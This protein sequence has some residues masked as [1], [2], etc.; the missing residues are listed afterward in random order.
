MRGSYANSWN[1]FRSVSA[2]V[3][4]VKNFERDEKFQIKL[5]KFKN[6]SIIYP[7]KLSEFEVQCKLYI[8]LSK[9]CDVRGEV[10]AVDAETGRKRCWFD[11]VVFRS[12]KAVCIVEV[13]DNSVAL[14]IVNP[15]VTKQL[16]KYQ[17]FGVPVFLCSNE[18]KIADVI[19]AVKNLLNTSK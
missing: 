16:L 14:D 12:S 13:K 19:V 4:S 2:G 3:R 6:S 15:Y 9:F 1:T 8:E 17:Q 5:K 7:K 11:L 18:T 10:R